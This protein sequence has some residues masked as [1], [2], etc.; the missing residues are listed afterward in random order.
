[1][2]GYEDTT[3]SRLDKLWDWFKSI[4]LQ[5]LE[6]ESK[7]IILQTRWHTQDLIGR[8][9]E[10]DNKDYDYI[11]LKALNSDGTC[12]WQERYTPESTIG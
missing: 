7:L 3:P 5:R 6:P 8:I 1:M 2:K 12:I 9:M 10:G 4:L 11:N